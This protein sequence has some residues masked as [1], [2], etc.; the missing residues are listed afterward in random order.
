MSLIGTLETYDGADSI[1]VLP[2]MFAVELAAINNSDPDPAHATQAQL[3]SALMLSGASSSRFDAMRTSLKNS[4]AMG[5]Q[6]SYP[7]TPEECLDYMNSYTPPA[8]TQQF[9]RPPPIA[10]P[11]TEGVMLAQTDGN[12]HDNFVCHDCGQ[13]RHIQ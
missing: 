1:G 8:P 11:V 12:R 4:Y 3:M 7:T 5:K 10:T 13:R 2:T 9:R 6:E